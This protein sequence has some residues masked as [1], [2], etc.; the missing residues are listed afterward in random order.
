MI[1]YAYTYII[2]SI[3][4]III[5]LALFT[6]RKDTRKEMIIISIIFGIGGIFSELVY[7]QDWWRPLT[8]TRTPI[9]LEDFLFGFAMGGNCLRYL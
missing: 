5:W 8:I 2:G 1:S 7:I 9:G 4:S 3:V 6:I